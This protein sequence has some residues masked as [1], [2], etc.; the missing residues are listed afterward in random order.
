MV[1]DT[2]SRETLQE[3]IADVPNGE[4]PS[5]AFSTAIKS[6]FISEYGIGSQAWILDVKNILADNA[7]YSN[8]VLCDISHL[9]LHL[10]RALFATMKYRGNSAACDVSAD[11][12]QV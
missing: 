9:Q 8:E 1:N 11:I 12:V 4:L 3:P 7:V 5:G 2:T 10:Q 6:H